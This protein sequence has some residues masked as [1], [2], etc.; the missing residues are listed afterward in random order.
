MKLGRISGQKMTNMDKKRPNQTKNNNFLLVDFLI[1]PL[2][3]FII[4]RF[5]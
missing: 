5:E 3:T 2:Y 1:E 4:R